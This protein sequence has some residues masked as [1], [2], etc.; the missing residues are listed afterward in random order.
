M[1]TGKGGARKGQMRPRG[2]QRAPGGLR[3]GRL[4]AGGAEVWI[5]HDA[6]RRGAGQRLEPR[7]RNV[8]GGAG[9]GQAGEPDLDDIVRRERRPS[10]RRLR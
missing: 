10:P 8:R 4:T 6:R 5:S 3:M 7:M 2:S 9:R 1:P